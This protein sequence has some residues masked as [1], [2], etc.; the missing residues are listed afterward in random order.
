MGAGHVRDVIMGF[1]S[2][3]LHVAVSF[4][5]GCHKHEQMCKVWCYICVIFVE[6]P[7]VNL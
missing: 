1:P 7:N 5:S 6:G 3:L 4:L 2:Y